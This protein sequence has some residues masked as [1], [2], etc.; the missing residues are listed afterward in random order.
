M[1][2]VRICACSLKQWSLDFENNTRRIIESVQK[3]HA[4]NAKIRSGPELEVTGYSC[5]DHFYER[6]NRAIF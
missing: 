1:S 6:G 5:G 2:L 4:N 3:A